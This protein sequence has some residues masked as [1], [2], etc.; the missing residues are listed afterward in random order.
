VGGVKTMLGLQ[1]VLDGALA[2]RAD[3]SLE[4][5]HCY[6]EASTF[7]ERF[8][9]E[10]QKS[11]EAAKA[12]NLL[13][14]RDRISVS[15]LIDDK[16]L[17][18]ENKVEWFS[19]HLTEMAGIFSQ[20]DYVVF[21][22]D[23]MTRLKLFYTALKPEKRYVIETEIER[24]VSNKKLTA[25]SHDIAIW[26]ALRAGA[27]GS[28]NLPVYSILN[29]APSSNRLVPSFCAARIVSVLNQSDRQHEDQAENEILKYMR[30]DQ[31]D[32]R[33]VERNYYY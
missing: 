11:F 14:K 21:E 8:T 1:K 27:L 19:G 20:V 33:S 6:W 12:L 29:S 3:M 15:V 30:N 24:Y 23:L 22:T 10:F 25:C 32:W 7:R 16:R 18:V 9:N 5:A 31:F 13:S 28:M 17:K 26:H 2:P 4:L